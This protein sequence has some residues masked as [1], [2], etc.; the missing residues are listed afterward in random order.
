MKFYLCYFYNSYKRISMTTTIDMNHF[1]DFTS[2]Q[3]DASDLIVYDIVDTKFHHTCRQTDY[4]RFTPEHG[5]FALFEIRFAVIT[6]TSLKTQVIVTIFKELSELT[7]YL[8]S[9]KR[10]KNFCGYISAECIK[11]YLSKRSKA[12]KKSEALNVFALDMLALHMEV[13]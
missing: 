1:F 11:S 7:N 5:G 13:P 8:R 6:E 10:Q 12:L 9:L 4:I 2:N 3:S